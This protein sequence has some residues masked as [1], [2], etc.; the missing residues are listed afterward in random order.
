MAGRSYA[1]YTLKIKEFSPYQT[2]EMFFFFYSVETCALS[3]H[4]VNYI[5]A[6]VVQ[7]KHDGGSA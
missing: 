4:V 7:K 5:P 3:E 2:N 1:N 6:H